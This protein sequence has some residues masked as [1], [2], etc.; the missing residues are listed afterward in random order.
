[1][2]TERNA[3]ATTVSVAVVRNRNGQN[4]VVITTSADPNGTLPPGVRLR[5]GETNPPTRPLIR[6]RIHDGVVQDVEVDPITGQTVGSYSP[7]GNSRNDF[8][9]LTNHHGEQRLQNGGGVEP[10]DTIIGM[11]HSNR[12]GCCPGCRTALGNSGNV[13]S[14]DPERF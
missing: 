4:R 7:R 13:G 11:S 10:G 3:N 2:T 14:M 9:G 1:V 12:Q 8:D 6:R 5:E